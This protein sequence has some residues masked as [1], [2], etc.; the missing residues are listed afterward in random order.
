[1]ARGYYTRF[2]REGLSFKEVEPLNVPYEVKDTFRLEIVKNVDVQP[3]YK[4]VYLSQE[5]QYKFTINHGSGHFSVTINNTAVADRI[6]ID[7]ERTVTIIPKR[8]GP[9]EIRVE[10]IEIPESI[11]AISELLISDIKS[12]E[13]DAPGTLIEQGSQMPLNVT[14]YDIYGNPFDFDQYEHMKFNIEIELTQQREK[15]L[16]TEADPNNRRKFIAKGFEPGNYQTAAFTFKYSPKTIPAAEM[17]RVSSEVLKIEVF[18]ILEIQPN[19]LLLTPYMKY[20]LV[21]AGG[22]SRSVYT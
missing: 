21:I 19:S 6:Y 11:V 3:K 15:G 13:L 22:P 20:T 8:E 10:D 18:P 9:I 14:A 12:L 16:Q 17:V 4:S 1:M 7:G 5:N 2:F